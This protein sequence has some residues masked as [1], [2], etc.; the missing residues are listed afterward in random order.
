MSWPVSALV[1]GVK[2]GAGRR[3][4][5]RRPGRQRDPTHRAARLIFLP[6][7]P[8]QIAAGHALDGN[9]R[10][11]PHEH[12]AAREDIRVRARSRA[13]TGPRPSTAGGWARCRRCGRTRTR[14]AA[15]G[16]C[17][18]PECPSRARSRTPKSGRWPR[19]PV[20]HRPRR[21]PAPCPCD[22][23]GGRSS[24]SSRG[25][26]RGTRSSESPASYLGGSRACNRCA[27][28]SGRS[29]E[30]PDILWATR[31]PPDRSGAL[32]RQRFP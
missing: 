26:E 11:A 31:T 15:S 9:R 7:R 29:A 1:A 24:W 27:N 3:S 32:H 8:G 2:I 5:S 10:R 16:P 18:C 20:H 12:R 13:G 25:G 14:K 17:P 22:R 19:S 28:G 30:Q 6:A 23:A 4:D 21:G